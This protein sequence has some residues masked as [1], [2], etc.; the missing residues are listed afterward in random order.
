MDLDRLRMFQVVCEEGSVSRAAVRLFRT[1]P[2]ISMQL[3]ALEAEA[4][5]RLVQRTGR[6]VVPTPEGRRLLAAAAEVFR[7]HD[8]L[9]EAWSTEEAGGDLRIA[10]SDTVARHFL[11]P[12]LRALLRQRPD[13][14]LHLVQSATPA[15]VNRLLAGEVE[16]AFLLR[17]VTEPR[18]SA[19]TVLRYSHVAVSPR[20]ERSPGPVD[21][22]ELARG[23][24]VLLARGTQTRNLVD[25]AFR[26]RGLAPARVVEVGSVS[27]QKELVRCGLGAGIVPAYAVEPRDRLRV[28]AIRGASVREIAVAW[29]SDL[30]LTRAGEAFLAEVSSA[31]A[32][33]SSC[34]HP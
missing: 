9:R 29:R 2:A 6:G 26:A 28:R 7:A 24:L 8:R 34:H 11:P 4:G 3:G 33:S 20:G 10:A 19:E 16:I 30:P 12:V 22:A 5:A 25:A 18:L 13:V 15:S 31:A 17:P 14:R 21:P 32:G 27:L 23:P 1:Q